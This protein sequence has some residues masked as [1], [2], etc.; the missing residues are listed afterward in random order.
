MSSPKRPRW[1]IVVHDP[2]LVA[3]FRERLEGLGIIVVLDRR[4]AE[5]RT[6]RGAPA[7]ERRRTDRRRRQPVGWVYPAQT[8]DTLGPDMGNLEFA[9]GPAGSRLPVH[10]ENAICLEC[11]I[12]IEFEMP[13]FA[14]TPVSVQTSV[15]HRTDQIFGV[16]HYVDIQAFGG[17]E[18]SPVSHRVHAQRRMPRR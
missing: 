3:A 17:T 2:E 11:G 10:V 9:S 1:L 12:A 16:Q 8:A 15:V 13:Q 4:R 14:R 6:G 7:M 5:R 18:Q